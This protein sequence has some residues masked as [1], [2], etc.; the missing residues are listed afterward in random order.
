MS[1]SEAAPRWRTPYLRMA[2]LTVLA[3]LIHGYHLGADDAAI[4]VPA[5][6]KAADPALYPFGDEFFM[7]HAHLSYFSNLVGGFARLTHLSIDL[8]IFLFH[9]AG[10]FLLL[11]AS[12]RLVSACFESHRARWGGVILLAMLL[13]VPVA[14]TAL[15]IM[16]PYL[17]ARSLST[18]FAMFAIAA[19]AE[20][21]PWAALLWLLATALVHPQMSAYAVVLV[22]L[23]ALARR[24]AVLA[25]PVPVFGLASVSW[26]PFV[27]E[28]HPASGAAR[29]ALLSRTY[30]F[31]FQWKWYEWVGVLVPL[32]I[33]WLMPDVCK[34][35]TPA[36]RSLA[37]RLVWFG[38]AFTAAGLLVSTPARLENYA[39]LQPMRAFQVIYVVL[40]LAV[41]AL[42]AQYALRT[43]PWRWIALFVPLALSLW[44]FQLQAYPHSRHLELPGEAGRGDWTA[45]FLWIRG[46]TPKDAVFALDPDY[47][48]LPGEDQHGFRAVAERSVLA[49]NVKDSGAVS[50]FP[51]LAGDW[52]QQVLAQTGWSH[53]RTGDFRDLA[54]QY[55]VSWIVTRN[56]APDGLACPYHNAE[57][58]VCRI[59]PDG[60]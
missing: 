15:V 10:V 51:Q 38:L 54:I 29:E 32:A 36:F 33:L 50:L 47:M 7:A 58:A 12:W 27:F 57:V 42:T 11:V 24:P 5:I 13:T 49:D 9:L 16:D 53:F 46:H 52:K 21:R 1:S 59:E 39:R 2:A 22:G 37:R 19:A 3:V 60:E 28:F 6:K 45:A 48:R 30:F 40:F 35:A 17:T 18:P 31:V 43:K 25:E 44:V 55:P 20:R 26:L 14:G 41:G 4:Y 34:D 23:M 56:P 8:V